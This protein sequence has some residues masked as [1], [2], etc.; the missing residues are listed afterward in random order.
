VF[1]RK[2]S[3][4]A[5]DPRQGRT[6]PLADVDPGAAPRRFAGAVADAVEALAAHEARFA[7]VQRLLNALDDTES[8]LALLD[9][10][11]GGAIAQAAEVALA[12]GAGAD[13]LD[14]ELS[15]LVDDLAALRAGLDAVR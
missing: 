5:K 7:S 12:A 8:Q 1:G 15:L 6:Q 3:R 9:V 10:R 13:E 14:G 4:E 2:R 11:L